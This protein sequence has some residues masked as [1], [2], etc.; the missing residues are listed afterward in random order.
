M[1]FLALLKPGLGTSASI[2]FYS[3]WG[4]VFLGRP[5]Y[6]STRSWLDGSDYS[7]ISIS[8]GCTVSS[9]VSFLTHD[10]SLNTIARAVGRETTEQIGIHGEIFIGEHCFIGRGCILMP[11]A[12]VKRGCLIGAGSVVRGVVEE[13]SVVV[14]N[15]GK[16]IGDSREYFNRKVDELNL[17]D[18][19][20]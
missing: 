3:R 12:V 18:K 5:N 11:G 10:W 2:Y 4:V 9:G 15:P 7:R 1:R 8:K 16:V 14:G 13:Y 20:K 19:L 6:L 17:S